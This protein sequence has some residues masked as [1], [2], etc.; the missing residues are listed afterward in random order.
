MASFAREHSRPAFI[1][2]SM[3]SGSTLLRYLLDSHKQLACPP[4]SKFLAALDSMLDYPQVLTALNSLGLTQSDIFSHVRTF[5]DNIMS[6]YTTKQGKTR[7]VDKT[8]SYYRI[9]DFIEKIFDR[10]AQYILL[11]RHPLDCICSLREFVPGQL[12]QNDPDIAR[13]VATYGKGQYGLAKYWLEVNEQI[14]HWSIALPDRTYLVRYEDLVMQSQQAVSKILY[15]LG[16]DPRLLDLN[17]ALTM[18]HTGGYQD[19]KIAQTIA[20]HT[21]SVGRSIKMTEGEAKSLWRL[22]QELA[23]K[24]GYEMSPRGTSTWDPTSKQVL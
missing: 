1:I 2:S 9:L 7:W 12:H 4:E 20:V 14:Y 6:S 15:F 5:V 10:S 3:R 19:P 8:P 18:S 21:N 22:V 13:V 24:F 16:E 17:K 23:T 11:V